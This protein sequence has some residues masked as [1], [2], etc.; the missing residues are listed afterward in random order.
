MEATDGN[1]SSFSS[2]MPPP[3]REVAK[4][5]TIRLYVQQAS[6]LRV[7]V[8]LRLNRREGEFFLVFLLNHKLLKSNLFF[9]TRT[10]N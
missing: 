2:F 5:Q 9:S 10:I 8:G 3:L 6:D 4:Y 1:V 7:F